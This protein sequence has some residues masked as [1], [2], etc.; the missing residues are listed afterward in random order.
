MLNCYSIYIQFQPSWDFY[1]DKLPKWLIN[2]TI[3]E[4]SNGIAVIIWVCALFHQVKFFFHHR[5][6]CAGLP[7]SF[8]FICSSEM[9]LR[10][11]IV[12]WRLLRC[13]IAKSEQLH[14][15]EWRT[16]C[17]RTVRLKSPVL[18]ACW[19]PSLNLQ[20]ARCG[21]NHDQQIPS[22]WE[23][24]ILVYFVLIGSLIV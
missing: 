15:H 2:P 18:Q 16:V 6:S 9:K 14:K 24:V 5:T 20:E 21:W 10:G 12:F 23:G 19:S 22:V 1:L 17:R 4:K 3:N 13:F 11:Y 8:E 7:M